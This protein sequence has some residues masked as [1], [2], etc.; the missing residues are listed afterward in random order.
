MASP[1]ALPS[2]WLATSGSVGAPRA[3]PGELV[4]RMQAAISAIAVTSVVFMGSCFVVIVGTLAVG[5]VRS[6]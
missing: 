1:S 6:S 5:L 4:A 2:A 3:R